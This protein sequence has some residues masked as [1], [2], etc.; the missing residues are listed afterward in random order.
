MTN[1]TRHII[2]I[3]LLSIFSTISIYAQGDS[4]PE[5]RVM[6]VV[7]D[8]ETGDSI[9]LANIKYT[10]LEETYIADGGGMFNIPK[11]E[12][13]Y[14]TF[15]AVGYKTQRISID[16]SSPNHLRVE[17]KPD[18]RH[19][20]QVEVRGKKRKYSRK[21]NPAV[22]LM[23]RVVAANKANDLKKTH[24]FYR[25]TNYQ[26]LTLAVNDVNPEELTRERNKQKRQWYL[27]QLTICKENG[28]LILP[29]NMEETVSEE[30]YRKSTDTE[31]SVVLGQKSE[32]I[33]KL[34][35]TGQVI[36]KLS[37]DVF[38]DIDLYQNQVRL[39][40]YPFTS[41]IG[42]NAV[43]FY[44]YYLVD[45]LMV[46]SDRC[47]H[48][49]F[50]PNNQQDFG[51]RGDL[52]VVDDS[53]LHVRRCELSIPKKSDV[54]WIDNIRINLEYEKLPTNEW[55]L[56]HDDLFC[57][58][59]IA[60]FI[61]KMAVFR[62]TRRTNYT[63]NSLSDDVFSGFG[64]E[65]IHPD[66]K[67]RDANFW[68]HYRTALLTDSEKNLGNFIS[69]MKKSR[70]F[71]F[72]MTAFKI[73]TENFIELGNEQHPSKVDIGPINTALTYNFIDGLRT[74]F[75]LSSTAHLSNH[76]FAKGYV[77]RGWKS[78][79]N[80]YKA[81]LT[82][83]L[84]KKELTPDE[85]PK[86]KIMLSA[87]YDN[88]SPSD[89]FGVH[90]KDNVF[91]MLRW[92]KDENRIFYNYRKIAFDFE[93][94][95]GMEYLMHY[96]WEKQRGVGN[97]EFPNM[98]LSEFMVGIRY[99][100]GENSVNTKRRRVKI[101]RD[102]PIYELSHTI[103][104]NGFLGG[105]QRYNTTDASAYYRLWLNS[106]G[107]LSLFVKGGIQWDKVPYMLL[108]QPPANTS[109][110]SQRHTFNL[111]NEMEF[112]T[113]RYAMLD[114]GWDL[115]GKILNRI[116]LIKKLKWREFIGFKCYWGTIS[117]KNKP[118][119]DCQSEDLISEA[120]N[121]TWPKGV[122]MLNGNKPYM[123]LSVGIHNVFKFFDIQ[124]VRR[125]NYLHKDGVHK[126]GIRL[127]FEMSF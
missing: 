63:F 49:E 10:K 13:Q 88:M 78:E 3:F 45:T 105:S 79:K 27:D 42:S 87:A 84:N 40:Q 26:K 38:T 2:V 22:E 7:V 58:L 60:S 107:K 71:G 95:G 100:P 32:G 118:I 6:G 82:Y 110:I 122:D 72:F 28:K 75:S 76:F 73:A 64:K 16:E 119:S 124:Y 106:W 113:D 89:R 83:S 44:R 46:G 65:R 101:N 11:R 108:L 125:L 69:G 34:I 5:Q 120:E 85:Y 37:D 127:K 9:Q 24:D 4:I 19:L 35:E 8:A 54:N 77:A 103:G 102:N 61:T 117:N 29:I 70:G 74:R 116:P 52:Y 91:T 93:Q 47:I 17:L 20:H 48:L 12:K 41:P 51:F 92:T 81:E 31:R 109:Y 21:E 67:R 59:S 115:N 94:Y 68:S 30:F 18:S 1:T 121:Y 96:K 56:T 15:S 43:N 33:N 55:A 97:I 23:R 57:E 50:I 53:T 111:L 14:L 66:S 90:D 36:N 126:N 80:Y 123:E 98:T 99:A 62:S 104:L 25:Y 114:A 39:L 112:L 86:R